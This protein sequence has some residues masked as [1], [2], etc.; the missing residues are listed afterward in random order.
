MKK[1][2][3]I[4]GTRADYGLLQP[5]MYK[6]N[7]DCDLQ[8]QIIATGMHLSPEFGLTY[9]EIIKDGFFISEKIEILLSSDTH[10]GISKSMGLAMI[11]FAEIYERLKPDL[12]V[13]LGDRYETFSA[14]SAAY[15]AAIP[16][17]HLYGG[18]T[19]VGAIDEAFRHSITKMSYIHFTSTEKYRQRVIQLGEHPN[20]VFNV[21]AIGVENI[22]S[23]NLLKK[24]E[25]EALFNFRFQGKTILLTYHPVTL[26][27]S[28]AE[29][30]FQ[31]LLEAIDSF[32]DLKVIFTK[33]NS[34]TNGRII[35]NLIDTYVENNRHKSVSFT[36]MGQLRYLSAMKY[37]DAVVG[38]SSSGI[39]EAPSFSVPT[40]NIGDRQ[41]GR[42]QAGSVC[43]CGTIT[44]EIV[45]SLQFVL[46]SDFRESIKNIKNPYGD[47]NVSENILWKLKLLLLNNKINLKK[48]FYDL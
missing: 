2:C 45:N 20:R 42:I 41:K 9:K 38:N 31:N 12:V 16:I 40:V 3:V 29:E 35:N 18:E 11:S 1:I 28:M 26:E 15:V 6:I 7:Q 8:L 36:S 19:T 22:K 27:D 39:V 33:C 4:T 10:I 23:I 44:S 32:N 37:V 21:G 17:A 24:E 13:F 48:E 14:A 30:Q 46:Y 5:L 43:N 34:D 25:L 47:G